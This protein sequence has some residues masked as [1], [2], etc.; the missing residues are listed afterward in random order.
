[1]IVLINL[2]FE[3]NINNNKNDGKFF[4]ELFHCNEEYCN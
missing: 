1:M 2:I 3:Y 4:N